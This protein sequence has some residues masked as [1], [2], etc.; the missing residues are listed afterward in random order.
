MLVMGRATLHS[1]VLLIMAVT[2]RY[3]AALDWAAD[4]GSLAWGGLADRSAAFDFTE[5]DYYLESMGGGLRKQFLAFQRPLDP[6]DLPQIKLE[7]G[8]WEEEYARLAGHPEPRPL[9]L[10]PGYLTPAKLVLASTKDH[11]HRLYLGQGIFAEVTLY[12]RQGRWQAREWTYPDYRRADFQE[13][14]L[15]VR[16]AWQRRARK[17][18]PS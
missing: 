10:D 12:F 4:R 7:T 11:V 15:R 16:N 2:S 1:P 8:R 18:L 9:N 5:T 13:F 17:E 14:F 3:D 6:A